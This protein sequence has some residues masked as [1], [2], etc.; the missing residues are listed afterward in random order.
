M[1]PST[2]VRLARVFAA[3]ILLVPTIPAQTALAVVCSDVHAVWARGANLAIDDFDWTQFV[4]TD[5]RGRIGPE[6][7]FTDYQL[8]DPGFGGFTYQPINEVALILE[9][10]T[11]PLP[12]GPYDNS[13][14]TGINE[15][16]AYMT[17]RVAQCANEVYVLG[18]YSEG[19]DV[20]GRALSVLPQSIRDRIAFVAL[21][22]DPVLDTGN[23]RPPGTPPIGG[24]L[25]SCFF[26]KKP[27]IRGS[28]PCWST[29]GIFGSHT[30]YVPPDM[31]QRVGS[32]CRDQD[33]ACV[34]SLFDVPASFNP[35]TNAHY[36]YFDG[37]SDS[38]FAAQEAAERLATY[39]P[40]HASSF[41][42]S[43][44]QFIFGQTGA[45]LAIVFD[46]TGSMSGAIANAKTQAT[47]LAETWLSFFQ[48]GRVGLAE[49]R[50]QGDLFVSRVDLALTNDP[51][52]FQTAVNALVAAGGGDT[53]EAQLSGIMAALDGM[54]WADGATK[55][56][57]VITDAVGKDPEPITG[58]TRAQVSQH[59]LEIDP[60]AIYGVNVSGSGTI[61]D[62]MTPMADVTA[63]EVFTLASGQSLSDALFDVLE[64]AH[65]S[66]VAKLDGPY[67]A[68]TG[69]A[70]NFSA[71][72]SFPASAPIVSYEW[73]FDLDGT[74]DRTT[75]TPTTTY[76][77]AGEY[78]GMA[79]VE[80]IADDDRSAIATTEVTVDSVGLADLQPI[81]PSS[82]AATV[83]GASQATVTWTPAADDRADGY[84][85]YLAD[86]TPVRFSLAADPH[87]AVIDGLDLSQPVQ[88]WVVAS[89]R[90]GDSAAVAAPSVGGTAPVT[91]TRVSESTTHGQGNGVSDDSYVSA[92]GRFVTYRSTSSNLV[93]GDTNGVMD[94]FVHDRLTETTTRASLDAAG[95]Q[96][97]AQSDDSAISADGRYVVF[98]SQASN[99]VTGDTNGTSW[100]IFRKD[101][102]TGAIV[103]VST[104]SSGAQSNGGSHDPVVSA[105]GR[106]VAFRSSAAN[107]VAGD[108]N[109]Q[110]DI[111]RK[112]V[113]TG[114][115]VL[116][117]VSS[118]GVQGN[119]LA[120]DPQISDDGNRIAFHSDATNLVATDTNAARD[121]FVR[122]VSAGTTVRVSISSSGTQGNGASAEAS[123]SGDGTTVAFQSDAS[124]LVG[125]DTNAKTDVFVRVL[126]TGVTSRV[127]VSAS[128]TQQTKAS[129]EPS[130][131]G[132]GSII[133][134]DS[135]GSG[136]VS[137][138]T[139]SRKDIFI[140]DLTTGVVTRMSV[141]TAGVQG[142]DTSRNASLSGDGTTVAFESDSTNL[143]ANDTNGTQDVF[144]RGPS[145]A[146]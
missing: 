68:K 77:Y 94:V 27:W 105:D 46:T 18:G 47:E 115:T 4:D 67:I 120:D 9:G 118:T 109:G 89:N 38:A 36:R 37:G 139:N 39:V 145:L 34:G 97:N 114:T 127:S 116:V 137:G 112:D 58:F 33:A 5:L 95:V 129:E 49:F 92:D 135:L 138:D 7:T 98:R 40:A 125:S 43:W 136:L 93:A 61:A 57:V 20:T 19:A 110:Q 146:Q 76:T 55:A 100:D 35:P 22:G 90:Y 62:W 13:V 83:T 75:A 117:S 122:D 69:T 123:I 11:A 143:V 12:F 66:P 126:A 132:D 86:G 28:A 14:Q 16:G 30:P 25:P 42:V 130:L 41:D 134:F 32:W 133:A 2:T 85:I 72:N 17:D 88:L 104:S 31:E 121:V 59:A 73:D 82:A 52:A 53:P 80:V 87:S 8:G 6:V 71:A 107:L 124:N 29:G 96:G 141:D 23:W 101:L 10:L 21:F 51:N 15:L 56:V 81:A 65:A 54:S 128:G 108:A 60:V 140:K 63:G 45:D 26:G 70:I 111:F 48:N 50:D 106:Y 79:S 131:S 119:A 103:R 91:T 24:F 64:A 99:F 3:M 144:V 1:R 84:K 74:I 142:N 44:D 102:Q 113:E 78:H